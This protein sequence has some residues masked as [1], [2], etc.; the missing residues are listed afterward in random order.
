MDAPY[1]PQHNSQSIIVHIRTRTGPISVPYR[2][3]APA[4]D[5]AGLHVTTYV[6]PSTDEQES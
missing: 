5:P 2:T 6:W 1:R 3:L 4:Q